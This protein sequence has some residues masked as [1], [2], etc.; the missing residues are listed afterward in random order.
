MPDIYTHILNGRESLM[1]I[2]RYQRDTIL[3]SERLFYLGCMGPD[4]FFYHFVSPWSASRYVIDLGSMMHRQHCGELI[5]E[6]FKLI[7]ENA[8]KHAFPDERTVYLLGFLCHYCT[9]RI[10][11]PFIFS[12]S[13]KYDKDKPETSKY[14]T[15]HKV[16]EL[17]IDSHMARLMDDN[18]INKL[19][20]NTFI[21]I[22]KSIPEPIED[23]FQYL[24]NTFFGEHA[25]KLKHRYINESY[26]C[27][28]AAWRAFYDPYYIKR[29]I[30]GIV[31][32]DI[33]LY[34]V[35]SNKRD[36]M[37]EKM[38]EWADPCSREVYNKSFI[39]V[40]SESVK[41]SSKLIKSAFDF[42]EDRITFKDLENSI[43]NFS[44]LTNTDVSSKLQEMKYFSP[45]F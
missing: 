30:L 37:N 7:K 39:E 44:Y 17:A 29:H 40:F 4:I 42:L 25:S 45:I 14:K 13:G 10:A 38:L 34:P 20:M 27:F 8:G 11:H 3:N 6:G 5:S 23:L 21:D 19:K 15:S 35:D 1:R 18:D 33:V 43:G 41:L 24:I 16:M 32:L 31:G 9:D 26:R 28:K 22:G 2:E 12:R 36:Y